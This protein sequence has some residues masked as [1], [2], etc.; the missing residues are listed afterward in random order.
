MVADAPKTGC[1]AVELKIME[2]ISPG[3]LAMLGT[4]EMLLLL[5]LF[6]VGLFFLATIIGFGL[7]LV[8]RQRKA[9][10]ERAKTPGAPKQ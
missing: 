5:V 8:I 7:W 9:A 3:M 4:A 10:A 1:A 2:P 6:A